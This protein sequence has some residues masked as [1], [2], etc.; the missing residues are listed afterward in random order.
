MYGYLRSWHLPLMLVAALLAPC[1]TAWAHG[2]LHTRIA[3]LSERIAV[4][5]ADKR[6]YAARAELEAEHGDMRAAQADL[7]QVRR[8][9]PAWPEVDLV[10]ARCLLRNGR[11]EA[12]DVSITAFRTREPDSLEGV[13][14]AAEISFRLKKWVAAE[15]LYA[16]YVS[17]AERTELDHYLRAAEAIAQQGKAHLTRALSLLDEGVVKLGDVPVL[18]ERAIQLAMQADD[19][20][21]ALR[22]VNAALA[23]ARH[24]ERWLALRGDILCKLGQ[25]ERAQEAYRASLAAMA[26]RPEARRGSALVALRQ[27]VEANL[28]RLTKG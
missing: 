27:R 18:R 20:E 25:T 19:H 9:D 22:R 23:V 28:A 17:Q 15:S 24:A 5:P 14:V 21:G 11:L 2:S 4:D 1:S 26:K 7:A 3:S 16:R 13:R 8:I 10:L 6:L 12:A